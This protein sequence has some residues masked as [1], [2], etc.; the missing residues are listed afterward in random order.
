M[1]ASS[2][3]STALI[4]AG[5]IAVAAVCTALPL[6]VYVASLATFGLAHVLAELRYVDQRFTARLGRGTVVTILALLGTIV[7]LRLVAFVPG[8]AAMP[9]RELELAAVAALPAAA[10]ALGVRRG[11][12]LA[13]AL[14]EGVTLAIAYGLLIAPGTTLVVLAL[15]HNLTPVGF[16]AERLRGAAR[17]RALALCVFAFGLVPALMLSGVGAA[18]LAR[19]GLANPDLAPLAVGP[20]DL[21]LGAFV[22]QRWL[23]EPFALRLFASAAYLQCAHYAVVLGVL[24]RLGA[25]DGDGAPSGAL[26]PWPAGRRFAVLLGVASAFALAGFV[27][28]FADARRVYGVASAVHAWSEVPVLLLAAGAGFG[29]RRAA[30]RTT[31]AAA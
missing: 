25:A 26:A 8:G 1:M 18:A 4:L 22:P 20:I 17:R 2:R 23:D 29:L 30:P 31:A 7:A 16:L 14:G 13:A 28:G 6:F 11:E 15:V 5:A 24:P 21:H 27:E 9:L 19:A 12:P 10:A 3:A